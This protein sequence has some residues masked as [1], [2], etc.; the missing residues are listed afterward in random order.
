MRPSTWGRSQ[1]LLEGVRFIWLQAFTRSNWLQAVTRSSWLQVV[2]HSNWPVPPA[3]DCDT[4][5]IVIHS[6]GREIAQS[7]WRECQKRHSVK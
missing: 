5:S 4:E 1:E 7:M 6:Q 3:T 2:T